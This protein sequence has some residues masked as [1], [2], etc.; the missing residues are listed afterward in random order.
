MPVVT[1]TYIDPL[2]RKLDAYR[3]PKDLQP[4]ATP[5]STLE[6]KIL[7]RAV[8]MPGHKGVFGDSTKNWGDGWEIRGWASTVSHCKTKMGVR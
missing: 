6:Q 4:E 5:A 2:Y 7:F 3:L 8:T 1:F